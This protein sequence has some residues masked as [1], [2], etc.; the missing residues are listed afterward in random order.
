VG[1]PDEVYH[2]P[3]TSF[4]FE[5]LGDVNRFHG[6][7]VAYARPY[8]IEILREPEGEDVIAAKVEHVVTRGSVIRVELATGEEAHTIE[9]DLTRE[10]VRDLALEKGQEVFIR[11]TSVR[12]FGSGQAAE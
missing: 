11:A 8:E 12:V 10:R 9:A 5:F 7:Q 3:A 1:T 6:K 2:T 4:V